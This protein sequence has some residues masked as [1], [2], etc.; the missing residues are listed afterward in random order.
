MRKIV[1][2]FAVIMLMTPAIAADDARA[3][4]MTPA[5]RD[6][7]HRGYE[8]NTSS[9]L[10]HYNGTLMCAVDFPEKHVWW[11]FKLRNDPIRIT[12]VIVSDESSGEVRGV[13]LDTGNG[14][15]KVPRPFVSHL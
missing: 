15:K 7:A 1:I 9:F 6:C 13:Y 3:M 8:H 4:D 5:I 2:L 12:N 11:L 10:M 14:L